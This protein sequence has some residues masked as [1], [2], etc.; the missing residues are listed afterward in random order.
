RGQVRGR[1]RRLVQVEVFRRMVSVRTS[2]LEDLDAYPRTNRPPSLTPSTAKSLFIGAF[3]VTIPA[4]IAAAFHRQMHDVSPWGATKPGRKAADKATPGMIRGYGF[5]F[6]IL[7]SI[8]IWLNF[9]PKLLAERYLMQLSGPLFLACAIATAGTVRYITGM[10]RR[11]RPS[12]R[13]NAVV[14]TLLS[15]GLLVG[16]VLL[17]LVSR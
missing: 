4:P 8:S 15:V 17:S 11:S 3:M 1:E 6:L 16:A 13:I 9:I 12:E 2:I 7:L 5:V 10:Q 14:L